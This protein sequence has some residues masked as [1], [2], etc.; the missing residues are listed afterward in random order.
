MHAK[1]ALVDLG[2]A[3]HTDTVLAGIDALQGGRDVPDLRTRFVAQGVDDFAVLELLGALLGIRVVTAAQV[4]SNPLQS[5][6]QLR[7]LLLQL[8]PDRVV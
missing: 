8:F 2:A 1:P 5:N 6:G 3:V 7:L 4:F